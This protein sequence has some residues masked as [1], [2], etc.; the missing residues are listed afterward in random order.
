MDLH[1]NGNT[2]FVTFT[3]IPPPKNTQVQQLF[4]HQ[5]K[6]LL[7]LKYKHTQKLQFKTVDLIERKCRRL[8]CGLH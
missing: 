8:F 3:H 2:G 1:V 7:V 5:L 6:H 4:F